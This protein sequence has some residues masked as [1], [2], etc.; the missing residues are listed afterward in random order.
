MSMSPPQRD[1]V[2][3]FIWGDEGSEGLFTKILRSASFGVYPAT[4]LLK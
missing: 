4:K 2:C 3:L 1:A